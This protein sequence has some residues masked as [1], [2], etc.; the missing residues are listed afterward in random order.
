MANE[1]KIKKGLI[2][3]GAS[4]GTVVD[5]QG[6]QGQLFSVT[7]N[8]SG[9]IFA[10]SDISGVPIF[11]VNSSGL[12]TFTGLVSGI[13]PVN[14]ANFVTKA[15]VDGSGGGTGPFL[16]L[17]GGTLSGNL[18]MDD[19][20]ILFEHSD[21][22]NY[23][24]LGIG[25]SANFEIY[26]TNYGRTDLLIT[27]S[28]GNATFAGNVTA[29]TFIGNVT[30][31]L[32]G[33]VTATSSLADGVT[34]TTQGDSDDSELIATTAFVQNL[35]E[36]IPAGL[37]FQGTWDA[38]T[39]TPTLTS[40]SGTTGNFYI[41]SVAGSTNLDGI[42]DWQVGDWAVFIEQGQNDQWE[43]IDNSSVLDGIGTTWISSW[44][45]RIWNFNIH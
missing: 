43:K 41:V 42:T 23:Y 36:T 18:T 13:T 22:S 17:A 7:D 25:A 8:L 5:I 4:G 40:G 21:G 27:Q 24:R 28:T 20:D 35:I 15:Y 6:S 1:F 26:N 39:N 31:N 3:T 19:S 32:T 16:P 45:G 38:S 37:V 12:S 14:A 44:M 33:I 30:G 11:D 29:P 34:G 9:S 10:V 2:V